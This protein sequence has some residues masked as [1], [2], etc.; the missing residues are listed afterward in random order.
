[1][2]AC[3]HVHLCA[4]MRIYSVINSKN[5]KRELQELSQFVWDILLYILATR[6]RFFISSSDATVLDGNASLCMPKMTSSRPSSSTSTSRIQDSEPA[7]GVKL[8]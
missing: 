8:R 4:R 5:H 3:M 7:S 2:C 1:M 6:Q